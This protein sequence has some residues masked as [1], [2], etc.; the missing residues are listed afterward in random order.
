[1]D[2]VL[3]DYQSGKK[4]YMNLFPGI[5]FPQSIKGF[6][7][8]LNP[9]KGGIE[10]VKK[11]ISSEKYDPYVLT[12]PSTRN[13]HSYSEKRIWIEKYFGY[14]FTK[15]LIICSNKGLLKGD[16]LI[17]DYIEGRGQEKFEGELLHFG[18]EVFP[19]WE[20]IAK[21]FMNLK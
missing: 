12:A 20:S 16:F 10:A 15:K 13:P 8:D 2:D 19:D 6:F 4:H 1:M 17:D 18:S 9:I 14:E 3:C 5:E 11:M 7:E 21:F